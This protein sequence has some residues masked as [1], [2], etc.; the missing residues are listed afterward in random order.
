M[1]TLTRQK[2]KQFFP[3]RLARNETSQILLPPKRMRFFAE[4]I[5]WLARI[6]ALQS[7]FYG[8]KRKNKSVLTLKETKYFKR[9]KWYEVYTKTQMSKN[10]LELIVSP[11]SSLKYPKHFQYEILK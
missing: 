1:K 3:Y 10:E 2:Y 6:V 9:V 5:C 11:T 8:Y 4:S 7:R